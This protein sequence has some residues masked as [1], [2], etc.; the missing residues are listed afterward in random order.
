MAKGRKKNEQQ[1]EGQLLQRIHIT[2][3]SSFKS[4]QEAHCLLYEQKKKPDPA[5]EDWKV[6]LHKACLQKHGMDMNLNVHQAL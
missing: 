5:T 3:S 2:G 6:R 1:H 4:R